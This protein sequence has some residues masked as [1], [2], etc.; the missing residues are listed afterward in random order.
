M[1][2]WLS[3]AFEFKATYFLYQNKPRGPGLFW[4]ILWPYR[5]VI[6][7]TS[8]LTNSSTIKNLIFILLT[9]LSMIR[10]LVSNLQC[11]QASQT[12]LTP[13]ECCLAFKTGLLTLLDS[14]QGFQTGLLTLL[15]GCQGFQTCL[16]TLLVCC[17][18]FQTGPRWPH[19][20]CPPLQAVDHIP[21]W[22]M[23]SST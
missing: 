9:L 11:F 19:C 17:Q 2:L 18:G 8:W 6:R 12:V 16:L 7:Q 13:I 5:K 23:G 1:F 3:M 10:R 14:C 4:K 15:D 20:T 22:T 21:S